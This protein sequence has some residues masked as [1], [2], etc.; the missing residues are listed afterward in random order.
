M[1]PIARLQGGRRVAVEVPHRLV[2][3]ADQHDEPDD[4]QGAHRKAD[5]QTRCGRADRLVEFKRAR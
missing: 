1:H 3:V 2:G 4:E 5:R